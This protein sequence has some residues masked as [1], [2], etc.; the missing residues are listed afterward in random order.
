MTLSVRPSPYVV[1]AYS[2]TGDLLAYLN[3][4][5]QYR[6]HN[7]GALPPSKPVQ[8][9]FGQ[10]IHGVMEEAYRTWQSRNMPLPW[11]DAE[12]TPIADLIIRRLAARGI[13]FQRFQLLGIAVERAFA[14]TIHGALTYFP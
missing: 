8:L 10:F 13:Y 3:C 4:G 6:Y 12:I 2:L 9:W 11:S 7:R 5:L 14:S 1:P